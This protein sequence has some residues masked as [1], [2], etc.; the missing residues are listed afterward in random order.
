MSTE[1]KNIS[2]ASI[3]AFNRGDIDAMVQIVSDNYVYHGPTGD[4]SGRNA[5]R[6]LVQMYRTGFPDVVMS[7][8]DQIAEGDKVVTRA[9][10]RGRHLGDFAGLAP[11][12]KAVAV[13]LMLID[14]IENGR[15]VESWEAFD[16]LGMLQ[17]LGAIP[18]AAVV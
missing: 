15:I 10:A 11:T 7:I 9:T 4:I 12:G 17:A 1:N 18:A 8:D 14:R 3:E 2:R 5:Y 16:Q 13:P 6:Q